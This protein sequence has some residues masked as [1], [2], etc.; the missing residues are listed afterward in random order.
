MNLIWLM[1]SN[2]LGNIMAPV[3][4]LKSLNTAP[5]TQTRRLSNFGANIV[6]KLKHAGV[7]WKMS[8]NLTTMM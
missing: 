2:Q 7:N 4:F 5:K 3:P 6:G 1:W 8:R